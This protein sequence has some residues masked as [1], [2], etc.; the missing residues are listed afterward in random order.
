[1]FWNIWVWPC[2]LM[3]VW[4]PIILIGFHAMCQSSPNRTN[5]RLQTQKPW[6]RCMKI[7]CSNLLTRQ[8]LIRAAQFN[9]S[10]QFKQCHKG[11]QSTCDVHQFQ[12]MW[13]TWRTQD[14]CQRH[15]ITYLSEELFYVQM[16]R[17]QFAGIDES[18][19]AHRLQGRDTFNLRLLFWVT[20][21][22]RKNNF[23]FNIFHSTSVIFSFKKKEKRKKG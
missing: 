10:D 4:F 17:Q 5:V 23:S 21:K 20:E 8:K 19:V 12:F 6:T 15:F 18:L 2:N 3:T 7:L 13:E 11:K 22:K 9:L 1:M 14:P 16:V